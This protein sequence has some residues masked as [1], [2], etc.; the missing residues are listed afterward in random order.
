MQDDDG[1]HATPPLTRQI[2]DV[3]HAVRFDHRLDTNRVHTTSQKAA[4][5]NAW[6]K[7]SGIDYIVSHCTPE[8]EC[9]P[10]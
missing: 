3:Q 4:S 9:W 5:G 2:R 6:E 7:K 1:L 10:E 8:D